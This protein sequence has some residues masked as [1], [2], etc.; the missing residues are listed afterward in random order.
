[1]PSGVGQKAKQVVEEAVADLQ[2][3]PAKTTSLALHDLRFVGPLVP[4][5]NFKND[6]RD[7]Y[8]NASWEEHQ[9]ILKHR[10]K[11]TTGIHRVERELLFCGNEL[12]VQG[13]FM[14]NIGQIMSVISSAMGQNLVFGDINSCI[15]R[16]DPRLMPDVA[17]MTPQGLLRGLGEIKAPW[18]PQHC[19]KKASN[20]GMLRKVL[21]RYTK[22]PLSL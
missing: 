20:N 17:F 6:V 3:G 4:W 15:N 1:M 10:P 16:K 13:R 11:G 14:Q 8:Q 19:L 22:S 21:G 2:I 7:T 9:A 12:S 18:V 5:K